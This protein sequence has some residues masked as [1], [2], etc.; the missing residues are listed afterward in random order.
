M[1]RKDTPTLAAQGKAEAEARRARQAEQLRANLARRKA[2]ARARTDATEAD[3]PDAQSE[4]AEPC[5]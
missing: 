2:Q 5:P 1:K 3:N 4:E